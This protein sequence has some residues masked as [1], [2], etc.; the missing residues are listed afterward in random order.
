MKSFLPLAAAF[1]LLLP[2]RALSGDPVGRPVEGFPQTRA[3]KKLFKRCLSDFSIEKV[4]ADTGFH[5][6]NMMRVIDDVRRYYSCRAFTE[7][8]PDV[9]CKKLNEHW[10]LP[11]QRILT[12]NCIDQYN[13][14]TVIRLNVTGNPKAREICQSLS[15]NALYLDGPWGGSTVEEECLYQ[16][17]PPGPGC[18]D[19]ADARVRNALFPIGTENCL[20]QHVMFGEGGDE[21][22]RSLKDS[23]VRNIPEQWCLDIMAYRKAYEAGKVRLCAGSLP[24]R[25]LMGQDVCEGHLDGL[26]RDYCRFWAARGR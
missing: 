7:N 16:T 22:C 10:T 18:K 26:R 23:G 2:A 19:V 13:L 4:V 5:D 9:F 3:Q 6:K 14:Y 12:D 25:M 1:C 15:L 20:M 21:V 11:P 8:N 17:T 24:C